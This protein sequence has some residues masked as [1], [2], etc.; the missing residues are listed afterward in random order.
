MLEDV[1]FWVLHQLQLEQKRLKN[2]GDENA[3]R[4]SRSARGQLVVKAI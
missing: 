4:K 3:R 2:K 1:L